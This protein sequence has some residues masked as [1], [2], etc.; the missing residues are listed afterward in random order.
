MNSLRILILS[1]IFIGGCLFN[2]DKPPTSIPE[3]IV[4]STVFVEVESEN[5]YSW[6]GSGVI[7]SEDGLIMTAGHIV[8]CAKSIKVTLYDGT[9]YQSESF[10]GE[11][12]PDSDI[13]FIKIEAKNLPTLKI[14]SNNELK[15]G[16]IIY[17]CGCPSGKEMAFTLT[18]GIVAGFDRVIPELGSRKLLQVDAQSWPGNSGGPI[19]DEN[20]DII[21]ILI[22][23]MEGADGIS[24][25]T[26][27][28]VCIVALEKY[29][30]DLML[31]SL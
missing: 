27:A 22:G 30:L 2:E 23:G 7:I 21:G 5:G 31:G 12:Y 20:G 8:N 24:L 9:V 18:K 1:V 19:C 13:G 6:S 10:Y 17:I 25:C 28:N 29:K 4:K 26:T 14:K 16:D 3:Q 15:Y 11:D